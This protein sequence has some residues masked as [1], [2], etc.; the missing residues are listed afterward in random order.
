M[1]HPSTNSKLAELEALLFLHGEPLGITKI[2]ELLGLSGEE[3]E[4]LVTS[5]A[6]KLADAERG[7][8]LVRIGNRVQLVTKSAFGRLVESFVRAELTQDLTPAAT[9]ALAIIAYLGPIARS[10]IEY[11]RG[12]NSSVTLRNLLIRGLV[13]RVSDPERPHVSTYQ[14]TANLFRH[15][16]LSNVED[17]PEL[18]KFRAALTAVAEPNT[19]EISPHD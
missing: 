18:T 4:R 9:E 10:R 5:S 11:L 3:T 13:E 8:T 1:N 12:V 7:L 19:P 14:A 6:E 16:G 2:A 17:L 15:L